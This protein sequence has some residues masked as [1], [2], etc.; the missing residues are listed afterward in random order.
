MRERIESLPVSRLVGAL[1]CLMALVM[2]AS[3]AWPQGSSVELP[4]LGGGQL[5][6]TELQSGDSIVV[7]WASWSPRGRDIVRRVNAI[8]KSWGNRAR[9]LTVNFQEDR[10][11]VES[12]LDGKQLAVPVYLDSTGVFSKKNAVTT[13]PG[14]L[15][16][17]NGK[18]AHRGRLPDDA[19]ALIGRILG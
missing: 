18:V 16:Y 3:P 17:K 10:A 8:E 1:A 12:F 4:G 7:V 5:R 19:E 2:A 6:E 13:L 14:L 15:I 11:A 9:V